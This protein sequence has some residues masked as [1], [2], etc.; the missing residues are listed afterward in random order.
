MR[1]RL[2]WLLAG[3]MIVAGCGEQPAPRGDGEDPSPVGGEPVAVCDLLEVGEVSDAVGQEVAAGVAD[4]IDAGVVSLQ[5]CQWTA[6]SEP[7]SSVSV[8]V[9]GQASITTDEPVEDVFDGAADAT[10]D[11]QTVEGVG[12]R[13]FRADGELHVLAG[14]YHLTVQAVGG[15][16]PDA[17]LTEL[18]ELAVTRL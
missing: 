1:R 13:A 12:D 5:S 15:D 10:A 18:A 2:L 7:F 4:E 6:E 11:P 16:V 14:P 3:L 9:I 8:S 17:A